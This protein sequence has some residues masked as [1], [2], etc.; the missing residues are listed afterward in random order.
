MIRAIRYVRPDGRTDPNC[1]SP[2]LKKTSKEL[3]RNTLLFYLSV[4]FEVKK[5][6]VRAFL[7]SYCVHSHTH[8]AKAQ[9]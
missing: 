9:E 1:R 6:E 2:A 5:T 7:S 8:E 3:L 4:H